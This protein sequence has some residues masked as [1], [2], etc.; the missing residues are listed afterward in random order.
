MNG[1][2]IIKLENI[3]AG[4]D[5]KLVLKNVSLDIFDHDF[6]GVIGPNGGGKT[7]LLHVILGMIRPLSGSVS[8]Y[9]NGA[10]TPH[11]SIG[12]LPQY[13]DIDRRF[14]ISVAEVVLSGLS[15]QKSL[16]KAFTHFHYEQVSETLRRIGM[17]DFK[18]RPINTLSG[19][20]LQRVFL[21]RAIVARPDVVVLDEPNTY[22][23]KQFQEQMYEMLDTINQD[24]AVVV[25]SH[26]IGTILQN[27]KTVACVNKTLHYHNSIGI[28]GS[29][30]REYFGCPIEL[31][32]H[33]DIPHHVLKKHD[34]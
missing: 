11:I 25:V 31:L 32:G 33:G 29:E 4:Y 5:G 19:G 28:S 22:I 23:D 13:N 3:S 16:L 7:T 21:A 17:D 12:Y 2:R 6:L 15:K 24:C 26:D 14:P 20:Q 10:L 18:D 8:Y 34:V 9:R 1:Q 30:L 27:V